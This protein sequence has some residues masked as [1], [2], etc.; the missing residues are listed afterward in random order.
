M[1]PTNGP[2]VGSLFE[3][4]VHP[5]NPVLATRFMDIVHSPLGYPVT[6]GL[7][8]VWVG[9]WLSRRDLVFGGKT[10]RDF[11]VVLRQGGGDSQTGAHRNR[12]RRWQRRQQRR[13]T[14]PSPALLADGSDIGLTEAGAG[15][16]EAAVNNT[17]EDEEHQSPIDSATAATEDDEYDDHGEEFNNERGLA[18]LEHPLTFWRSWSLALAGSLLHYRLDT[19]Y[20]NNGETPTYR[21]II[22]T[23]YWL[24]GANDIIYPSVTLAFLLSL[25]TLLITF[26][27]AFTSLR[28]TLPLPRRVSGLLRA[29][30]GRIWTVACVAIGVAIVYCVFFWTRL[31]IEPRVP[32]V[33]EEADLG[34]LLFEAATAVLPM[35][36]CGVACGEL[37]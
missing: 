20:E 31:Q 25:G 12:Q 24:P 35:V 28:T 18:T 29:R 6:A 1:P 7:G 37:L 5:I 13:L 16:A 14:P 10:W 2:D 9:M 8:W 17:D 22:S 26:A 32:A 30:A 15:A 3:F 11:G 19:L 34:V 36:L 27:I 23:G 33:G 4:L 21:W